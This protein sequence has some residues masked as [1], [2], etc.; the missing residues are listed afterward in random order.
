MCV[1]PRHMPTSPAGIFEDVR[2]VIRHDLL[3]LPFT[4]CIMELGRPIGH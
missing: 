2:V 3:V 1:R 4:H